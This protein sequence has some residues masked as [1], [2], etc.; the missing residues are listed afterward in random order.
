MFPASPIH[1]IK[2]FSLLVK[3]KDL[4]IVLHLD[5]TAG[6]HPVGEDEDIVRALDGQKWKTSGRFH[7]ER[8]FLV[9]WGHFSAN[10]GGLPISPILSHPHGRGP[11]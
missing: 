10:H 4:V 8:D 7:S 3:K 2:I 1:M 5:G 6:C 11:Q 9:S